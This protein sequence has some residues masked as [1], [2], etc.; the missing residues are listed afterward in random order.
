MIQIKINNENKVQSI[1]Y[2]EDKKEGWI[3]IESIP[4]P[5]NREGY[6]PVMY[7]R[8]GQIE[9]EYLAVPEE[10]KEEISIEDL[11][12]QKIDEITAYDTSSNVNGFILDREE[13]WLDKA[14]RVGLMNSTQIEKA[15]GKETTT[16]WFEGKSYTLPCDTAIQML[17]ALELYALDCYNTT[18]QHKANVEALTTKEEVEAYDYTTGYPSKLNLSTTTV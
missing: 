1:Y 16:L 6:Y 7:Y 15:A 8:N 11:K 14:T 10:P 3:E 4:G 9:Y 17:S 13:V 12:S 18:A 5:E 2:R